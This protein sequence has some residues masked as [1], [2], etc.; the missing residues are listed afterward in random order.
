MMKYA[1]QYHVANISFEPPVDGAPILS[2]LVL[3]NEE[4]VPEET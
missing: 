3:Q 4:L 1:G 2:K